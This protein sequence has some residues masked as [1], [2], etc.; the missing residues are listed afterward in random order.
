MVRIEYKPFGF[1]IP[2]FADIFVDSGLMTR[3]GQSLR[4]L[5]WRGQQQC[6]V[7]AGSDAPPVCQATKQDV[8][9]VTGLMF[10]LVIFDGLQT[11]FA[12]GIQ[13]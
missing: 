7:V 3:R 13:S 1:G 2:G 10:A 6:I 5:R 9:A 8:D 12:T 4:G 11:G